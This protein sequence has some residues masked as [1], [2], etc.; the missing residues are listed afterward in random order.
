MHYY[1][2]KTYLPNPV[3]K[4]NLL[5]SKK[6]GEHP[7]KEH[8]ESK[9]YLPLVEGFS[10]L[11]AS[12]WDFCWKGVLDHRIQPTQQ[13]RFI[14]E[15]VDTVFNG[16]VFLWDTVMTVQ[17]AKYGSRAFDVAGSLDNFYAR[18]HPDGFICREVRSSDG[19]ESWNRHDP[20]STGPDIFAWGEWDLY[21][22]SGDVE[23]L[24]TVLPALIGYFYWLRAYRRWPDGSRWHSG[25]GSGIDNQPRQ[26]TVTLPGGIDTNFVP[27]QYYWF[28]PSAMGWIDATAQALLSAQ[29]LVKMIDITGSCTDHRDTIVAERDLLYSVIHT[30]MYNEET[31]FYSDRHADGTVSEIK[32]LAAYWVILTDDVP[33]DRVSRMVEMLEDPKF[34]KRPH[35]IPA[36]SADHPAYKEK[37]DY[38]N[39]GVWPPTNYLVLRALRKQGYHDLAYRIAKNHLDAVLKVFEE[40]GTVWENYAPEKFEPGSLSKPDMLGWSGLGPIAVLIEFICGVEI[41][42]PNSRVEIISPHATGYTLRGLSVGKGEQLTVV[43]SESGTTVE[44]TLH[45]PLAVVQV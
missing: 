1:D 2:D 45:T 36:L 17:Y 11:T 28:T 41:D 24:K 42:M 27:I 43:S 13:N 35:M 4:E 16:S 38:W 6:R 32:S 18:Q 20:S 40:T 10:P 30:S 26:R 39:G 37:G 21:R 29:T 19:H 7:G 34:F 25:W 33:S 8:A 31:G 22:L 5:I 12:C 23:R 14:S 44:T 3:V 15:A 9:Q